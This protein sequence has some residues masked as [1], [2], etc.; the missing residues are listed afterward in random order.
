MPTLQLA[1]EMLKSDPEQFLNIY[2]LKVVGAG[3]NNRQ[4][5]YRFM[6]FEENRGLNGVNDWHFIRRHNDGGKDK[7]NF[8]LVPSWG[9]IQYS[10]FGELAFPV[11]HV[12]VVESTNITWNDIQRWEDIP[13]DGGSDIMVTTLLNACSFVCVGMQDCVRM[14]HVQ[15]SGGLTNYDVMQRVSLIQGGQYCSAPFDYNPVTTEVTIIGIRR[16]RRWTVYAQSHVR[17]GSFN[18]KAV[19]TVFD[20]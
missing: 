13:R 19:W 16:D 1:L 15:P 18:I 17:D 11:W 12:P 4:I 5:W 20:G 3:R 9:Q 2:Y 14:M 10:H 8:Q 6:A 7:K